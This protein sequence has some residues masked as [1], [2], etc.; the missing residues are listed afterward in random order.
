MSARR[1][2][3]LTTAR[4]I[5]KVHGWIAGRCWG[6]LCRLWGLG[7]MLAVL[8]ADLDHQ[9]DALARLARLQVPAPQHG[10]AH[11]ESRA[12]HGTIVHA[13]QHHKTAMSVARGCVT[14]GRARTMCCACP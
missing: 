5:I 2:R 10:I 6:M 4:R 14:A 12:Q 11:C 8:A 3:I 7:L 13:L 9:L 1:V